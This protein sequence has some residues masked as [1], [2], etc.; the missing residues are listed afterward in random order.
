[1]KSQKINIL[2]CLTLAGFAATGCSDD[3][4]DMPQVADATFALGSASDCVEAFASRSF[5]NATGGTTK[6]GR[7]R[8]RSVLRRGR[9]SVDG[10]RE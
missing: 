10:L 5:S 8:D 4:E 6:L 2:A 1:M 7:H 9:G 3:E